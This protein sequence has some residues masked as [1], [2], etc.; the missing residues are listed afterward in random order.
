MGATFE[1]TNLSLYA[2]SHQNPTRLRDPDGNIPVDTVW[3]L[4]NVIVDA[5]RIGYHR[6]VT[7]DKDAQRQATEDLAVDTA[8]MLIP[9]VP[10]GAS[11]VLRGGKGVADALT[12][13]AST[14][15]RTD[16]KPGQVASTY[17]KGRRAG[18]KGEGRRPTDPLP[19]YRE[20]GA[21]EI[22]PENLARMEKGKPPIGRDGQPIELHHRDQNP[23]GPLD[24]LTQETHRGVEHP[25]SPSRIDRGKFKGERTRYW[26]QR[27]RELYGQD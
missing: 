7:G 6:F 13:G 24:E 5:G 1:P 16:V 14:A 17:P 2:Y 8:S 9:Y 3:D 22:T 21:F 25:D 26:R 11:K 27:A 20:N 19:G 23:S 10:A 15:A 12:D 4:G 18:G